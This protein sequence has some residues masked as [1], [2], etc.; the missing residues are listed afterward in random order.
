MRFCSCSWGDAL[1]ATLGRVSLNS[2]KGFGMFARISLATVFMS[3]LVLLIATATADDWTRF[4]GEGGTGIAPDSS[5]PTT[6]SADEN[7]KW[8]IEL[9]G[10]GSSSPIVFGDRVYVTCY[11]GFGVDR[12]DPGEPADLER[13]L[14]CFD[15]ADGKE[16][17]RATVKSTNP[18]DPYKGFI[19]EHG[20]ASSTPVT[21]GEHVFVFFG[22]DGVV[23]FDMEGK[24]IWQTNVG[25]MSDP[26][27]WGGGA[28]PILHD[29]KV[30]VN[31][32]IEGH[33]LIALNKA[34]GKEVWRIENPKFTN[35]WSTP[36]IVNQGKEAELVYSVP[37][38][39]YGIDPDNGKELWNAASPVAQTVTTSTTTSGD[40]IYTLGGRQGRAIA[41]RSGGEGDVSESHTV[42]TEPVKSAIGTPIVQGDHM[43]WL[44]SGSIASCVN[45]KNGEL[46]SEVRLADESASGDGQR[47][48]PAGNYAS[49]VIAG[50]HIYFVTRSGAVHVVK[51]DE[52]LEKVAS[53][54]FEG[55]DS[56]F[57]ATPAISD[58]QMFIRSDT[59]LYCIE[60]E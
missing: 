44:A 22:K 6:W 45:T 34:D 27:A 60:G 36:V 26:A 52:T 29:D 41:L 9:P 14:I 21:D 32:G 19:N 57:N 59:K 40:V 31:A 18:E 53:N 38:R 58:D 7:I 25:T 11:T 3:T 37:D 55:D 33:A 48:G 20:Y 17:W 54:D 12:K 43:F 13:H 42:W 8:S 46:V 35:C 2:K 4:R 28:S 56:L 39:L 1:G 16:L 47:R 24:Q 23:A 15:R 50:N 49:P 51:A 10:P 30:I 5:I